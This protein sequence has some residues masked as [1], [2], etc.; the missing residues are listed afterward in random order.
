MTLMK[1]L[2]VIDARDDELVADA[3]VLCGWLPRCK[4]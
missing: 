1:T 2:A 4:W 3:S